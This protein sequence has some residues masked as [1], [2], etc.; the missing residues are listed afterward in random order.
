MEEERKALLEARRARLAALMARMEQRR[1]LMETRVHRESVEEPV[2]LLRHLK[3]DDST[4]IARRKKMETK[5]PHIDLNYDFDPIPRF[6]FKEKIKKR[7][8]AERHEA[9]ITDHLPNSISPEGSQISGPSDL[10]FKSDESKDLIIRFSHLLIE[11]TETAMKSAE[12][13]EKAVIE[14]LSNNCHCG[15]RSNSS[16]S[17]SE[18]DSGYEVRNSKKKEKCTC[19][20]NLLL[21][22]AQEER[23]RAENYAVDTMKLILQSSRCTS[24]GSASQSDRSKDVTTDFKKAETRSLQDGNMDKQKMEQI[25]KWCEAAGNAQIQA[26]LDDDSQASDSA[27]S[28]KGS[29]RQKGSMYDRERL[30]L[31]RER[32][33]FERE[34]LMFDREKFMS[35]KKSDSAAPTPETPGSKEQGFDFRGTS[36]TMNNKTL[37]KLRSP[38]KSGEESGYSSLFGDD[39]DDDLYG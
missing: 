16:D 25:A 5:W 7:E 22:S 29:E 27:A 13:N 34:K 39:E 11:S 26:Q 37:F 17:S 24:S 2:D 10:S 4:F 8:R 19:L 32:L 20:N 33:M 38:V 23:K 3:Q 21:K 18:S 9:A 15:Q 36:A 35:T 31:E 12:R 1:E 28:S 6:M 30:M 14:Y